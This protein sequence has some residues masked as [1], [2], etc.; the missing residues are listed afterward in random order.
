MAS[1]FENWGGW[2][3]EFGPF[4]GCIPHTVTDGLHRG[5]QT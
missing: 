1:V 4:K 2:E 3:V 5:L